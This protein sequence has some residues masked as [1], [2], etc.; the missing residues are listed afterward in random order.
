MNLLELDPA[1]RAPFARL[2]A[3]LVRDKGI[4]AQ[5]VFLNVLESTEALEMNYW[6]A[7][8]LLQEHFI[9]P[10]LVVAQDA[11]GEPVKAL[12]AACV[13]KN[14]GVA[15]AILESHGFQGAVDE[16]EFQLAARI[17]TK[18]EDEAM[19]SLLMKYAQEVGHL[20]TFMRELQGAKLN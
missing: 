2:T 14:H 17:A 5:E 9:S 16:R 4:E 12:Q 6:M 13:L 10:Q 7:K 1:Q 11:T 20:E 8:V 15:A 18:Q 19:M 3:G